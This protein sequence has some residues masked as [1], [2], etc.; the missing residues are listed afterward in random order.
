MEKE[1]NLSGKWISSFIQNNKIYNEKVNFKQNGKEVKANIILNYEGQICNYEFNG[2]ITNNIIN[3]TYF[4]T[5]DSNVESGTISLK[6]I[7]KDFLY[8]VTTYISDEEDNDD[9]VQSPYALFR[10]TDNPVLASE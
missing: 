4:Y 1:F 2:I 10:N 8:G 9:I 3:G 6:I 5:E 7:N